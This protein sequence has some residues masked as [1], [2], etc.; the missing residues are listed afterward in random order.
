MRFVARLSACFKHQ[1]F[2]ALYGIKTLSG[3]RQRPPTQITAS[4]C[5]ISHCTFFFL[6][7][8]QVCFDR[9]HG[10]INVDTSTDM[11]RKEKFTKLP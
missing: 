11:T 9:G 4:H 7:P 1:V 2:V 5:V 3:L 10:L 8:S 6:N